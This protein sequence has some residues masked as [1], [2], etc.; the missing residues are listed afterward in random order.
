M[1]SSWL[2][3]STGYAACWPAVAQP[4]SYVPDRYGRPVQIAPLPAET[5]EEAIQAA[6]RCCVPEVDQLWISAIQKSRTQI[7]ETETHGE[8]SS[9]GASRITEKTAPV[10]HNI[11]VNDKKRLRMLLAGCTNRL[12]LA[13]AGDNQPT[14]ARFVL[15]KSINNGD[16]IAGVSKTD[17][18]ALYFNL[19]FLLLQ[20]GAEADAYAKLQ[21]ASLLY[22]SNNCRRGQAETLALIALADA[23]AFRWEA[24]ST[25]YEEAFDAYSGDDGVTSYQFATSS[26]ISAANAACFAGQPDRSVTLFT[27]AQE[28]CDNKIH[29]D[30]RLL[31]LLHYQIA[32]MTFH[33]RKYAEAQA[34]AKNALALLGITLDTKKADVFSHPALGR[35][36]TALPLK[37]FWRR[38]ISVDTTLVGVSADEPV[39]SET[40]SGTTLPPLPY[41]PVLQPVSACAS[42][43]NLPSG[44]RQK[45]KSEVFDSA[46]L[47]PPSLP[48]NA[49]HPN[50]SPA[51]A[52]FSDTTESQ[53]SSRVTADSRLERLAQD[54]FD[55]SS[56]PSSRSTDD[57]NQKLVSPEGGNGA[58]EVDIKAELF[59]RFSISP[60]ERFPLMSKLC[61][62]P[63][64]EGTHVVAFPASVDR[65]LRLYAVATQRLQQTSGHVS[66]A[67]RIDAL[68][69]WQDAKSHVDYLP[70]EGA[71]RSPKRFGEKIRE[72][73]CASILS[74][75][76]ASWNY[77][78]APGKNLNTVVAASFR[79][80]GSVETK[81]SILSGEAEFDEQCR[82]V[83]QSSAESAFHE[84]PNSVP[85]GMPVFVTFVS[86]ASRT[87]SSTPAI[88][89]DQSNSFDSAKFAYA[90]VVSLRTRLTKLQIEATLMPEARKKAPD[91]VLSVGPAGEFK[92]I[93]ST[94]PRRLHFLV[95][96]RDCRMTASAMVAPVVPLLMPMIEEGTPLLLHQTKLWRMKPTIVVLRLVQKGAGWSQSRNMSP[97]C[98]LHPGARI[99]GLICQQ[100][101][102]C[103]AT[104]LKNKV[105]TR[106][107]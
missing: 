6:L 68:A 80:G 66:D 72:T 82:K 107:Q 60:E 78:G 10:R 65:V 58:R 57:E 55:S 49:F 4:R 56:S 91:T 106:M 29:G 34:H 89:V 62:L 12:A 46:A 77:A 13:Y 51:N 71:A 5:V 23:R 38:T 79:E 52:R 104:S 74:K 27:R 3:G 35:Q 21:Q 103:L 86:T 41:G 24:A 43:T 19:G 2:C 50:N 67:S 20:A 30:A 61:L 75:A 85:D 69:D 92:Q 47:V 1:T 100:R 102:C 18:A 16:V 87:S 53:R 14:A 96:T 45:S 7:R 105:A 63:G 64:A 54:S 32:L 76:K 42:M 94:I 15:E 8:S 99:F 31:P 26:L 9:P 95:P 90:R 22:K 37:L 97:R 83:A 28:R 17:K 48:L 36:N 44:G 25:R 70:A 59:Q 93:E 98:R 73:L 39:I 84:A 40:S 101:T 81:V 33:Q 11:G 88:F